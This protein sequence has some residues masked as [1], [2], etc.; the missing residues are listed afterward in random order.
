MNAAD[1]DHPIDM[2]A[3]LDFVVFVA[4]VTISVCRPDVHWLQLGDQS[5]RGLLQE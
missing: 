2:L 4:M 3:T 5:Q 1:H